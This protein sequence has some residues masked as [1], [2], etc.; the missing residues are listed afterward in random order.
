MKTKL[1]IFI[2]L[3]AAFFLFA[4]DFWMKLNWDNPTMSIFYTTQ[5]EIYIN[6][7]DSITQYSQYCSKDNGNTWEKLNYH[8]ICKGIRY[9]E[10]NGNYLYFTALDSTGPTS[11]DWFL[12]KIHK[13]STQSRALLEIRFNSMV[14]F[15]DNFYFLKWGGII[16]SNLDIADTNQVLVGTE[17]NQLF[18]SIVLD[19]TGTIYAGSTNYLGAGGLYRSDDN[20]D[21]WNGPGPNLLDDFISAM[22]VDSEGRIFAGTRGHYFLGTGRIYRSEDNGVSWE[23]VAGDG[24]FVT[25]M[26]INSEDKIFVGLASGDMIYSR[27]HGD[28]WNYIN[29]GLSGPG[30]IEHMAISPDEYIYLATRGGVYRSVNS[31]SINNEQ[32]IINNYELDQNYPNPFNNQ[33]NI[34]LSIQENC[35]VRLA[36]YNIKG[37]FVKDIFEGSLNKGFYSYSFKADALNSGVYF[38]NIEINGKIMDSKK[39]LYLK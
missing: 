29:E 19:S 13:D 20:G 37:E 24:A 10:E 31:T 4:E 39:M 26:V 16:K 15:K 2:I 17:G 5:D 7:D 35:E 38:Y 9:I 25:S 18:T 23:I 32:L 36:V 30:E 3:I 34:S 21:T 1:T 28:T 27:D 14:K 6:T 8:K 33:T 22:V 12:H 11:W